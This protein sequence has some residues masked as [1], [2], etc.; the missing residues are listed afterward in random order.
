MAIAKRP[1]ATKTAAVGTDDKAAD[2]F[3]AK[4]SSAQHQAGAK[5]KRPKKVGI[6]VYFDPAVLEKVDDRARLAGLSR[7]AWLHST[8][9]KAL[10]E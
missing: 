10:D 7:S 1:V 8:A 9:I 2:E 4:A 5:P 3:I 6:M